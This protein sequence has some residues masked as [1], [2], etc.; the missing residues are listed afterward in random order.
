MVTDV[1]FDT[2]QLKVAE[3]PAVMLGGLAVKE[4]TTGNPAGVGGDGAS[5]TMT[6][7]VAVLLPAA[8]VA[9]SV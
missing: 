6:W 7:A 5:E 2:F 3:L 9:V 4:L 8:L 1:A